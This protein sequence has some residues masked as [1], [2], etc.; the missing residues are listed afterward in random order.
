MDSLRRI[1]AEMY[2]YALSHSSRFILHLFI[3]TSSN[4]L[5]IKSLLVLCTATAVLASD[6][7]DAVSSVG[8]YNGAD[9]SDHDAT[10]ESVFNDRKN[11]GSA[12][13]SILHHCASAADFKPAEL[14]VHIRPWVYTEFVRQLSSFPALKRNVSE[15]VRLDLIGTKTQLMGE[16]KYIYDNF[17]EE[18]DHPVDHQ[19]AKNF[20]R[21]IPKTLGPDQKRWLLSQ[22]GIYKVRGADKYRIELAR[23]A[24]ELSEDPKTRKVKIDEQRTT[25][26]RDVYLVKTQWI[27]EHA[28]ILAEKLRTVNVEQAVAFLTTKAKRHDELFEQQ[29]SFCE[30]LNEEQYEFYGRSRFNLQ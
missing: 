13:A 25:L 16:I 7:F 29:V 19:V 9:L 18:E 15:V 2:K 20:V 28:K 1:L 27:T 21:L 10:G 24:L 8:Y 26:S 22:V 5:L 30:D 12:V 4:M 23:V 14:G 11:R 17:G 3:N 6:S